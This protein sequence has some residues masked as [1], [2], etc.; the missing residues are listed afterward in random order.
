MSSFVCPIFVVSNR[1]GQ[2]DLKSLGHLGLG[3]KSLG[4]AV[5]SHAHPWS[6]IIKIRLIPVGE[7]L[8]NY[9]LVFRVKMRFLADS[10]QKLPFGHLDSKHQSATASWC[11][12]YTDLNFEN[13]NWSKCPKK[14]IKIPKKFVVHSN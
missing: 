6:Q 5:P 11:D 9:L 8:L 4:L 1:D 10:N 13:W 7:C 12:N 3:Q 14:S 2:S